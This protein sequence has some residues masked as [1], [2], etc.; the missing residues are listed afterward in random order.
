MPKVSVYLPQELYEQAKARSLP[1]SSLAQAAIEE[2]LRVDS[3]DRW[4]EKVRSRPKRQAKDFDTTALMAEVRDEF[5][6]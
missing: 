5:E 3:T 6:R 4:I 1:V 2:A